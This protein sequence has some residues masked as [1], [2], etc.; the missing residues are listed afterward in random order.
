MMSEV[1]KA[2]IVKSVQNEDTLSISYSDIH[3][4]HRIKQYLLKSK[5]ELKKKKKK[6]NFGVTLQ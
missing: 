1:E 4:K 3:R 2:W 6:K 5:L